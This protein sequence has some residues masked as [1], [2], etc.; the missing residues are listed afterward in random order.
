M[1]GKGYNGRRSLAGGFPHQEGSSS[2]IG[3]TSRG[4]SSSTAAVR[5]F[6]PVYLSLMNYNQLQLIVPASCNEKG[7][8]QMMTT[9]LSPER[10]HLTA[11][12]S[13]TLWM[14]S[15]KYSPCRRNMQGPRPENVNDEVTLENPGDAVLRT[16][17]N[18]RCRSTSILDRHT[19][20]PSSSAWEIAPTAILSFWKR[21]LLW[22]WIL[23]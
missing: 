22:Y 11:T 14:P 8:Q 10:S 13:R 5:C 21:Y 15:I 9:L 18:H 7:C 3:F 2:L 12:V 20:R 16:I 17:H 1:E 23:P 4:E 6:R 19:I